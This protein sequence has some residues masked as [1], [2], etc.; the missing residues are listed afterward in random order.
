[1]EEHA[2][3]EFDK[4]MIRNGI[5]ETTG[6]VPAYIKEVIMLKIGERTEVVTDKYCHYLTMA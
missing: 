4:A 5:R 6:Q 1:M 3:H 2:G